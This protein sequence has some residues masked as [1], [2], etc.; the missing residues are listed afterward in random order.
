[1]ITNQLGLYGPKLRRIDSQLSQ[2]PVRIRGQMDR[3]AD[4]VGKTRTLEQL[5]SMPLLSKSNSSDQT[6]NPS[7]DDEDTEATGLASEFLACH[8]YSESGKTL[9][10]A[11]R[12]KD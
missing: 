10:M 3:S 9:Q 1:M 12:K 7:A 8:L 4:F 6:S 11:L 2:D 5:N